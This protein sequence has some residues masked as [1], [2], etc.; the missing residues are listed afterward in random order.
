ML[1]LTTV[2]ATS[3]VAVNVN[4]GVPVWGPPVPPDIHFYYLPDIEVYYD[5]PRAHFIYY[6]QG[7]WIRS[8]SLP[9]RCRNYDL[10]LGC[11]VVAVDDYRGNEPYCHFKNHKTKYYN[12]GY[13][14]KRHHDN[15]R[16]EGHF[17]HGRGHGKGHDRD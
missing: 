15:G 5:L 1:F 13:Y 4:I 2:S 8:R 6:D 7:A 12:G 17:K 14:E 11:R 3:Q 10:H 16:H 9:Y